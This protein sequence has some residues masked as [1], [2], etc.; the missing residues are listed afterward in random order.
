[1]VTQS[2]DASREFLEQT[3]EE[4]AMEREKGYLQ[5]VLWALAVPD[6]REVHLV[7]GGLVALVG[8]G[9]QPGPVHPEIRGNKC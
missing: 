5:V 7:Q 8:L 1:M 6:A 3:L 9:Y 2:L 4:E